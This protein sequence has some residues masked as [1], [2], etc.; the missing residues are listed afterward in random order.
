MPTIRNMVI[1]QARRLG[2]TR[3]GVLAIG[4]IVSPLQR[5]LYRRTGGR[6]SLTG[7]APVLLLTTV[8]RRSGLPRTV[9]LFYVRDGQHL[10][11]CNVNPGFERT[12]PWVLNLRAHPRATVQLRGEV[13]DVVG[14][15]A[16]PEELEIHWPRLRR[17]WPAYERFYHQGGK[18]SV[19]VLE[20]VTA[21]QGAVSGSAEPPRR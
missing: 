7:R 5:H 8:G 20:R 1:E 3:Y 16:S 14:R 12:N 2:S 17:I 10:V 4:H 11:V 21:P 6:L 15:E 13:F 18:R 9:P 19:F